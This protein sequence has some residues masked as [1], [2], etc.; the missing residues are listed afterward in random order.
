[1]TVTK[2]RPKIIH[3]MFSFQLHYLTNR[4]QKVQLGNDCSLYLYIRK[5][6]PNGSILV[7]DIFNIFI[8]EIFYV[9]NMKYLCNYAD[10]NTLSYSKKEY[11]E[12]I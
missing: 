12:L 11:E 5:G 4:K 8:N 9:I 1:M 2:P 3:P 7:P 10:D 6:L